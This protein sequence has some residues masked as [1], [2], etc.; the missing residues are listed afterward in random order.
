MNVQYEI[1]ALIDISKMVDESS[2]IGELI[3]SA[4]KSFSEEIPN[5]FADDITLASEY[6][7]GTITVDHELT[8]DEFAELEKTISDAAD[9]SAGNISKPEC[10]IGD[11]K[12]RRMST[13]DSSL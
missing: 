5:E 6:V 8:L 3:A 4:K 13:E 11:L 10:I 1:Y 9:S 2:E 12:I 7:F